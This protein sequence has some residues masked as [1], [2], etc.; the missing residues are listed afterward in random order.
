MSRDF[1]SRPL[2]DVVVDADAVQGPLELWRHTIGHGGI[3]HLPLP[4]R[5]GEGLQALQP[6]LIRIFLQ[7]FFN[8][9]PEHRRFDWSRLDPTFAGRAPGPKVLT[10]HRIDAQRRWTEEPPRLQ[11]VERR[12]LYSPATLRCQ[13][14]EA[15]VPMTARGAIKP[16]AVLP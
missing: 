3:N 13:Y 14:A 8:I 6:R 15:F 5:V 1:L 2:A 12:R 7:E 11:Q 16:Y 4:D 10:V 9:Y